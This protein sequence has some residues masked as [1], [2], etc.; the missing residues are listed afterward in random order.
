VEKV[1]VKFPKYL[2]NLRRIFKHS[3]STVLKYQWKNLQKEIKNHQVRISTVKS[4]LIW[5]NH[6]TISNLK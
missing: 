1:F 6:Q 3:R 2:T 5:K 4:S